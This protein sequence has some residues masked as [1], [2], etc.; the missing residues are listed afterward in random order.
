MKNIH[1]YIYY[2]DKPIKTI[3]F[4][5]WRLTYF[6]LEVLDFCIHSELAT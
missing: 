5:F 4:I 1:Y 3:L 6:D 2:N